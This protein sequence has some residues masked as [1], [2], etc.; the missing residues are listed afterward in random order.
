MW[1]TGVLL[2]RQGPYLVLSISSSGLRVIY[3]SI[4]LL[5]QK[6]YKTILFF[7]SFTAI[8][9]LRKEAKQAIVS[10]SVRNV[11]SHICVQTANKCL[12]SLQLA[13]LGPSRSCLIIAWK[14]FRFVNEFCLLKCKPEVCF[15][16]IKYW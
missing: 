1:V 7:F 15:R 8:L 5:W 13:E 16:P 4:I 14:V 6:Q 12:K 10:V 11:Y 2:P 3:F 9:F